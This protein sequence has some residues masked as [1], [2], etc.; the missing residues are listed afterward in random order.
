[1]SVPRY[2][3]CYEMGKKVNCQ[4]PRCEK[5]HSRYMYWTGNG[6]PRVYCPECYRY[7]SNQS[8][9]MMEDWEEGIGVVPK[10]VMPVLST[11]F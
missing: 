2:P 5:I 6:R 4:C 1:M 10:E 11:N 3:P 8:V 9:R 7:F